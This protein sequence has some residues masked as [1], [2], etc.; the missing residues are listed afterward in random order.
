MLRIVL[1]RHGSTISSNLYFTQKIPQKLKT[2]L[3]I[4]HSSYKIKKRYFREKNYTHYFYIRSAHVF[5]FQS[6]SFH[7]IIL[8]SVNSHK[9]V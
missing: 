3:N 4:L 9:L 6:N 5:M 2:K 1:S 8:V 7:P